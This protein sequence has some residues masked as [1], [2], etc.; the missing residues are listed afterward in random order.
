MAT[1]PVLR[2]VPGE[3]RCEVSGTLPPG[4]AQPPQRIG[5]YQI[6]GL[7]GQGGMGTVY[8]GE[9]EDRSA[10]A[11]KVMRTDLHADDELLQRFRREITAAESISG[12]HVARVLGHGEYDGQHW[13]ATEFIEGP[14]LESYLRQVLRM[15]PEHVQWLASH[16]LTALEQIHGAG[17]IHRDITPSNVILGPQH[18]IIVDF[19][20]ARLPSVQTMTTAG[21]LVGTPAWMS[22]EQAHGRAVDT[23]SDLFS[24]GAICLYAATG[25]APFSGDS[26][27]ATLYKVVRKDP[28]VDSAP[29]E[30]Q[31]FL[32]AV[33][34]KDP[35][36][37]RPSRRPGNCSER[38]HS[39]VHHACA[40][41]WR[42]WPSWQSRPSAQ[43]SRAETLSH[44]HQ[45]SPKPPRAPRAKHLKARIYRNHQTSPSSRTPRGIPTRSLR[46]TLPLRRLHRLGLST[47]KGLWAAH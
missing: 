7:I 42:C 1:R 28:D 31:R 22:P 14:T 18:P 11:A 44:N 20:I 35:R 9:T 5:P 21:Q 4:A 32:H 16:L 45:R 15:T 2:A 27:P 25:R 26:D 8:L 30:L 41:P 36:T 24:L 17:V 12:S 47:P 29:E 38:S 19:G 13:V 3:R 10:V 46:P 40:W 43:H 6:R 23:S 33:L 37:A 39:G 34:R